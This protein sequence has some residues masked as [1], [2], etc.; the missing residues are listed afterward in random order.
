MINDYLTD[1]V[2]TNETVDQEIKKLENFDLSY[3]KEVFNKANGPELLATAAFDSATLN[4]PV[5]QQLIL[6][7]NNTSKINLYKINHSAECFKLNTISNSNSKKII[8]FKKLIKNSL[9]AVSEPS[10]QENKA[11]FKVCINKN[12]FEFSEF[13]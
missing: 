7:V 13:I 8:Q 3:S 5:K 10:Q 4:K 6:N 9:D 1:E 12:C 2:T 11:E